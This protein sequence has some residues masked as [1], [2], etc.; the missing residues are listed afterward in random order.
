MF[1]CKGKSCEQEQ[2]K[3]GNKQ[4]ATSNTRHKQQKI[5]VPRLF[6]EK[7]KFQ[8]SSLK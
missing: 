4:Q 1:C 5:V 8:V 7:N 6:Q 2:G 3:Q